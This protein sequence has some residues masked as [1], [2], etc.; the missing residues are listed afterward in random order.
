[1]RF[2]EREICFAPVFAARGFIKCV[3]FILLIVPPLLTLLIPL[4]LLVVL[5][6]FGRR[7][8]RHE[9]SCAIKR[10]WYVATHCGAG[11]DDSTLVI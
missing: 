8:P 10:V 5:V 1:M 6:T 11:N 2:E 7:R 4:Y 9:V 3:L